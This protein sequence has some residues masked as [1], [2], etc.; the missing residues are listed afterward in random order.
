MVIASNE[1]EKF[2]VRQL[3]PFTT[4]AYIK[5]N[6][7]RPGTPAETISEV[8]LTLLNAL[9]AVQG[10]EQYAV[11]VGALLNLP[12]QHDASSVGSV[13]HVDV[14]NITAMLAG[15]KDGA[16]EMDE[17][18]LSTIGSS[19]SA[20]DSPP[21]P[22]R[23]IFDGKGAD[24][25]RK[26]FHALQ[27]IL[28]GGGEVVHPCMVHWAAIDRSLLAILKPLVP[29]TATVM[30]K[31]VQRQ[32]TFFGGLEAILLLNGH[33]I[34]NRLEE[35]FEVVTQTVDYA[36]TDGTFEGVTAT[37][38]MHALIADIRTRTEAFE[39]AKDH[40]TRFCLQMALKCFPT[41]IDGETA[42]VFNE[43]K[44]DLRKA[45]VSSST[46]EVID[47]ILT[48]IHT[49]GATELTGTIVAAVPRRRRH[50]TILPVVETA[51][52]TI[53]VGGKGGSGG[54]GKGRGKGT[55]D[56]RPL[57]PHGANCKNFGTLTGCS[58]LHQ[59]KDRAAMQH[60]LGDKFVN[61]D[62]RMRVFAA[63]QA[64]NQPTAVQP[65]VSPTAQ[66]SAQQGPR[67]GDDIAVTSM[68]Q[69][70]ANARHAKAMQAMIKA[71]PILP[72]AQQPPVPQP[73][74]TAAAAKLTEAATYLAMIK[75]VQDEYSGSGSQQHSAAA[76]SAPRD[77][78]V[79]SLPIMQEASSVIPPGPATSHVIDVPYDVLLAENAQ[80]RSVITI[81]A[82]CGHHAATSLSSSPLYEQPVS[83]ATS[84]MPCS[85]NVNAPVRI[86]GYDPNTIIMPLIIDAAL[87]P[88]HASHVATSTIHAIH[89][90]TGPKRT[91]RAN[92]MTSRGEWTGATMPTVMG[93]SRTV[94]Q[95]ARIE[96]AARMAASKAYA[97]PLRPKPTFSA[98][99]HN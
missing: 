85:D 29:A 98:A 93:V 96:T 87:P 80:L 46:E 27:T 82:A 53:Y 65:P 21:P 61:R 16:N 18:S 26:A 71:A 37:D 62:T 41:A 19:S 24:K 50:K 35:C 90:A 73:E 76:M 17:D 31:V 79:S 51:A 30:Y 95:Q 10:R 52:S 45:D 84:L 64:E 77:F 69:F 5:A 49:V 39:V 14:R 70:A 36:N 12:L 20:S 33:G 38:A 75:K 63:M 22:R 40:S 47:I 72:S 74:P 67:D 57:C 55:G 68:L 58:S 86:N 15:E 59:D 11:M 91:R 94:L 9:T 42:S 1:R 89:V 43:L 88:M 60:K 8:A 81:L 99:T 3:A 13:A 23:D 56:H 7:I 25:R 66:Q 78:A 97:A 44:R 32:S 28:C 2:C 6:S 4:A 92:H 34:Q 54:T 48:T 83:A